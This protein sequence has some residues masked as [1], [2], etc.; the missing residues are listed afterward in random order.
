MEQAEEKINLILTDLIEETLKI[1][2]DPII[3]YLSGQMIEINELTQLS[4]LELI[5]DERSY[6]SCTKS[7]SIFTE[8]A[9]EEIIRKQK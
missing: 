3:Y 5:Y 6:A 8:E 2:L 7:K 4:Q 1:T 9:D